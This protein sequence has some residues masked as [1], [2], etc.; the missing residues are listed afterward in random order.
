M[1]LEKHKRIFNFI[2]PVYNLFFMKQL[3]VYSEL[4]SQ[5][6]E[7]LDLKQKSSILDLGCGTG[8]F[9]AAFA[10]LGHDVS[11]V[12]LAD[13][14]VKQARSRG[15]NCH[16]GN[17]LEGLSFADSSFDLIIS[18]FVAHGL[19]REK[20]KVFMGEA[21]RISRGPVLFHD[22]SSKRNFFINVIEYLEDG[23]YFNFIRTGLDEMKIHFSY[24]QVIPVKPYNNW[25][26]CRK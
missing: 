17:I 7:K 23:D 24:V 15:L 25:Y 19:D 26:L 10:S 18:S 3:S 2:S 6:L 21:A 20:R 4:L 5:H 12:D 11:G 9:G 22:Y 8:A 1:D 13:R 14:M 16:Q